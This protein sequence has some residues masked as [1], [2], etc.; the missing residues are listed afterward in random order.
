MVIINLYSNL[1]S[2]FGSGLSLLDNHIHTRHRHIDIITQRQTT[3]IF[4]S[5]KF[6]P[7]EYSRHLKIHDITSL[8]TSNYSTAQV[9]SHNSMSHQRQKHV[10]LHQTTGF[11]T[12]YHITLQEYSGHRISYH[13]QFLTKLHLNEK[14]ELKK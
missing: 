11:F 3:G 1:F 9:N 4:T 13:W 6:T 10:K 14:R 8:L 7:Q 5:Y 12:P 2:C